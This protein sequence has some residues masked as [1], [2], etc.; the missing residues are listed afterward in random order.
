MRRAWS[1]PSGRSTLMTSAPKSAR[2]SAAD[3]PATMWPS[4]STRTPAS[5]N[6]PPPLAIC[7]NLPGP[8]APLA[9]TL[10]RRVR[11]PQRDP[12]ATARA[13]HHS[14]PRRAG[15]RGRIIAR[16]RGAGEL[17]HLVIESVRLA[18]RRALDDSEFLALDTLSL[19]VERGEFVA[20]VGP[21]GCGKSTLL[22][23]VNALLRP[24]SGEILLNGRPV[25]TPGP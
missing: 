18:Y 22:L 4:S 8:R 5:G 19:T 24:T 16:S 9:R 1:P 6:G 15:R 10:P 17:Q 21:S 2:I 7:A 3:G 14:S 25:D 20:I 11:A 23:L 13:R 12:A